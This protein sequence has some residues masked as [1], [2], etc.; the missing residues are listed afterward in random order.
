MVALLGKFTV[1]GS[2][3]VQSGDLHCGPACWIVDNFARIQTLALLQIVQPFDGDTKQRAIAEQ[4]E[5][6]LTH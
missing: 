3:E 6:F 5:S 2:M 1:F 4:N